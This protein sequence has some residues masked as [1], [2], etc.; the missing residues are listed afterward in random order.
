MHTH[1]HIHDTKYA[2]SNTHISQV[3]CTDKFL[4]SFN[5]L[6]KNLVI[7]INLTSWPLSFQLAIQ[8]ILP[9][10]SINFLV[11]SSIINTLIFFWNIMIHLYIFVLFF[12]NIRFPMSN[13][14]T[15]SCRFFWN[16]VPQQILIGFWLIFH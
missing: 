15:L 7:T 8:K 1:G 14:F 4:F 2:L 12:F 5:P 9:I 11:F 10:Y 3:C 16:Q 6:K 13:I